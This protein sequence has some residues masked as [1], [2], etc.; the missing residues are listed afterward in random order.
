MISKRLR[1]LRLKQSLTLQQIAIQLGV[2]RASVSKWETNLARPE[3]GRL[4]QL[5]SI[6][7]VPVAYLL[8]DVDSV[9]AKTFP[10]WNLSVSNKFDLKSLRKADSTN[11]SECFTSLREVGPDAF[12]VRISDDVLVHSKSLFIAPNSLVLIDPAASP[13]S[14]SVVLTNNE[15][16]HPQFAVLTIVAGKS[17]FC[18]INPKYPIP[19]T[20]KLKV[21]GVAVEAIEVTDLSAFGQKICT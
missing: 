11:N 5:A 15:K 17:Y 18:S 3:L 21:L 7:N 1:E 13:K 16:L 19:R 8:G 6:Y 9:H 2:T 4:E 10:I 20:S 14:G 12:F